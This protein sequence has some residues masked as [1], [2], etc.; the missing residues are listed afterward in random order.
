[1]IPQPPAPVLDY[2]PTSV[3]ASPLTEAPSGPAPAPRPRPRRRVERATPPSD[4]LA[5]IAHEL[6][7]PLQ[8]LGTS[9][10][11]LAEDVDTLSPS[12]V[13]ETAL[14]IHRRAVWLQRL[15]ENLLTAAALER[16]GLS[17]C[18]HPT[19]LR[20]VVEET[21]LVVEPLLAQRAQRLRIALPEH[22]AGALVDRRCIGQ[23]LANLLL[24]AAKFSDPGTDV[25]VILSPTAWPGG[26]RLTIADRG[27]GIRP[28]DA[29]R[30]FSP[31]V[32]GE[33]R[34]DG[35]GLGLSIVRSIAEAHNGRVGAAPRDGGG[36]CFW[37]EI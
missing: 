29:T 3:P 4:A 20:E 13:R 17:V 18:A 33:T 36:A 21:A 8:S 31:Y 37:I 24:N 35:L 9:A 11:L 15:A 1:M 6:R 2:A 10:A 32:R 26:W 25:D 7:G 30:L 34:V 28:E 14:A 5:T 12:Q 22:A 16:G 23:A 19:D 27:P